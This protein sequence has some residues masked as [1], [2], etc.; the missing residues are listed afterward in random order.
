MSAP[1]HDSVLPPGV[2]C[3]TS[4]RKSKQSE[5]EQGRESGPMSGDRLFS[6]M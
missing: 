3:G 4:F 2:A 6:L 5:D 1:T